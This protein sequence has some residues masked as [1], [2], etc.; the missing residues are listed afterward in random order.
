MKGD[1]K[2]IEYLNKV[3]Y[4]ELTAINQYFLHAHVALE[5]GPATRA[6]ALRTG[7]DYVVTEHSSEILNGVASA[8]RRELAAAVYR[9]AR[10][11]IAVS[12]V[13]AERIL[14]ICPAARVR[15]VGNLVRD[16]VFAMVRPRNDE[17]DCIRIVSIGALVGGKRLHHA[18][19]A[20]ANLPPA[21]RERVVHTIV[22]DGP[23]R[24]ML[25]NA[26]RSGRVRTTFLGN[27][28]HARAMAMLADADLL[29]HPSAFETFGIV[30]AEAMALG[31]PVV[32]TRCGGPEGIVTNDTGRLVAVDDVPALTAA[33]AG[34]VGDIAVWR[35]RRQAIACRARTLY[36]EANIASA[37]ARSYP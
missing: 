20:L 12:P 27:Q 11:V 8:S 18:I 24:M 33:I 32:A 7:T 1:T 4:N 21:I 28:P 23:D 25:E 3:L 2:V 19:A 29:L 22:G 31:V 13:L 35:Q 34:V 36:H 14:D 26:A 17:D 37:I 15:V 10:S 5:A 16:E 9:D 30:L 6:I